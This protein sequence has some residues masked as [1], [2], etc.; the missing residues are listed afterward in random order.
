MTFSSSGGPL[1]D[2]TMVEL[3]QRIPNFDSEDDALSIILE[4]TA[5][6]TGEAFFAALVE[7]LSKAMDT[8][9]AWVTEY[10]EESQQLRA[11]AFWANG[12]LLTDFIID[13]DGTPC[14]DVIEHAEFIHHPDNIV[15]VYPKDS[16][17][18]QLKAVSYMGVPL[19]DTEQRILGHLAVLDT[20][21]LKDESRTLKI[22]QIFAAR[23]S[24]ELQRLRVE[25]DIRKREEKYRRIVETAREGFVLF[26]RDYKITDVNEMYCKMTGYRREE[27]IGKT[28][29]DFSPE[30]HKDFLMSNRKDLFSGKFEDFESTIASRDGRLIPVLVHSNI[31]RNDKSEIIGKMAFLTD[32]TEHKKSLALAGE[33]QKSLLPQKSPKIP[34][35]DIAGKNITCDEIGG[36]YF[37]FLWDLECEGNHFDAVVGDVT[38]HGVDAALLMTSARAFLRMRA[39]QCGGISQIVTEMNRHLTMD[40]L[41]TGRF[42]TMFYIS[43]DVENKNLSWVRAGHDP[44]IIYDPNFDQFEELKGTGLALGVDKDYI[45]DE[46]IKTGLVQG[47][48]IAIG[49]DGIWETFNKDGKMFGKERFREIIRN[50]AHMGSSDILNAIFNE[51]DRFSLGVKTADDITLVIIKIEEASREGGDWQI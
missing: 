47:Q 24:A 34:G 18:K 22:F 25:Q 35:L 9:S 16:L 14:G 2:L 39:S 10:M 26:D 48:I 40:I 17:L 11:L 37:D 7:N 32:M 36:D 49:T 15:N 27:I 6:V 45:F 28:P 43:I 23:A 20:S 8:H 13:M 33:I 1:K 29:L 12:Q 46:N 4:G 42:M 50:N 5:R 41:H 31:L 19:W 21:P 44:A 51:I 30:N 3:S 38:G